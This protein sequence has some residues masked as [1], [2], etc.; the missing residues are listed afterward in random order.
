MSRTCLP[1]LLALLI[2][3]SAWSGVSPTSVTADLKP[4]EDTG[5]I[6]KTVT[7]PAVT[8]KIDV[9]LLVDLSGSYSDDLRNLKTQ[10]GGADGLAAELFDGV[11]TTEVDCQF[12]LAS[13]VDFPFSSWGS[14]AHGDYGYRLDLDFTATRATFVSAVDGLSTK[15]GWDGPE[16]QYEALYQ[17]ATGDG[18]EMPISADGDYEDAGEIAPGLNPTFRDDA[19]KVVVITTDA[20]FHE[21][22][23]VCTPYSGSGYTPC[24]FTYP[25]ANSTEATDALVAA[26]IRVIGLTGRYSTLTELDDLATA[27]GGASLLTRSDS[28]DI[29]SATLEGLEALTF[30]VGA[31]PS[32]DCDPLEFTYDPDSYSDVAGGSSVTF[33]ETIA[34]P[35]TVTE[36]DLDPYGAITCHVQFKADDTVFGTQSVSITVLLNSPPEAAC[37]DVTVDAAADTCLGTASI[38]DG[39]SDP[40]GDPLTY[41]YSP[42]GPYPAGT[43]EVTLTVT[44]P[45]GESDSCTGLVTVVDATAPTVSVGDA[46]VLWPPNHKFVDLG[47]DDCDVTITD[48]CDGE[49]VVSEAAA[50]TS[51]TSDEAEDAVGKGDGRTLDDMVI[52]GDALFSLRAERSAHGDG[53]V[54]EVDFSITDG[55]GNVQYATCVV[56]VPFADDGVPAVDSG[57]A[58]TV[59]P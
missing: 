56:G 38:D 34:V 24:S 59:T 47:L 12:A 3:S 43:T 8:P 42:A 41:S 19:T 55:A 29:V 32:A 17:V 33:D 25:G 31:Y 45:D 49:L 39:S 28:A 50:I 9:V 53:R 30:E 44:D 4:G 27:T 6:E 18:R 14:S 22:G 23:D 5:T 57:D 48:S 52:D 37:A 36:A 46:L 20:T 10:V 58:W 40:D 1:A 54:Y 35:L 21:K 13:Y 26:G 15:N 16:S 7:L 51:I 11:C 2:S